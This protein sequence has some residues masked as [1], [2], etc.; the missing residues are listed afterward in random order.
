MKF[1]TYIADNNVTNTF[2]KLHLF[3]Y[4]YSYDFTN[5]LVCIFKTFKKSILKM[6]VKNQ[7]K[8]D[9]RIS[10]HQLWGPFQTLPLLHFSAFSAKLGCCL[11]YQT[12]LWCNHAIESWVITFT[13]KRKLERRQFS[14]SSSFFKIWSACSCEFKAYLWT[15]WAL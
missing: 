6:S 2:F 4:I 14:T 8:C 1:G 13:A 5:F 9:F 10:L 15:F 3:L 11:V 12:F 7:F